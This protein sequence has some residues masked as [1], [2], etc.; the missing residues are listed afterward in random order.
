[1]PRV[2]VMRGCRMGGAGRRCGCSSALAKA[3]Q[4]LQADLST[5]GGRI[6][7]RLTPQALAGLSDEQYGALLS[8]VFNLGANPSWTIWKV[9]NKGQLDQSLLGMSYLSTLGRV[10]IRGS[11]LTLER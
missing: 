6:A 1:M 10:E 2:R 8:F 3:L 4:R 9:I 5:A 11:T 7:Q